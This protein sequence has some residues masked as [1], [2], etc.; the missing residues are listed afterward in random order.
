[1]SNRTIKAYVIYYLPEWSDKPIYLLSNH[2]LKGN[3]FVSIREQEFEVE[4][5]EDFNPIPGQL[6]ALNEQEK[7][8]RLKLADELAS[9]NDRRAKLQAI[10]Y[11][12]V[13]VVS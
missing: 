1:M 9:I 3:G 7:A 11:T 4:I 2:E 10:E 6:A 12:P 5:P 8:A 13:E